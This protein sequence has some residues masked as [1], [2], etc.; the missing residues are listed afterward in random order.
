[1]RGGMY[2]AFKT[3]DG[4]ICIAGVHDKRW[5]AFCRITGIEHLEN[6]PEISANVVR[7]FKGFRIQA[8]MDEIFPAQDHP[9]MARGVRQGRYPGD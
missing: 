9:R 4:Y 2:S 7:N 1:M 8:I 3:R 5:H 6:D